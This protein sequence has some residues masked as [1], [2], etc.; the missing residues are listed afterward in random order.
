MKFTEAACRM[1]IF[2]KY[3]D[4]I[5]INKRSGLK[6]DLIVTSLTD[7]RGFRTFRTC[8]IELSNCWSDKRFQTHKEV[9]SM[10]SPLDGVKDFSLKIIHFG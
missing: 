5:Y 9:Q 3:T 4:K 6:V 1:K 2:G 7:V 10:L 8:L